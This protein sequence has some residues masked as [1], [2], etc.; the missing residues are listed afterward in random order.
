MKISVF[1]FLISSSVL[2]SCKEKTSVSLIP[3]ET[4]VDIYAH[5]MIIQELKTLSAKDSVWM[6]SQLDSLYRAKNVQRKEFES[7]LQAYQQDLT[8]WKKFQESV[9]KKL[10]AINKEEYE[11]SAK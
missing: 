1:I 7:A 3:E 10:E 11:K 4:M 6:S 9:L 5:S 2:F 8:Q